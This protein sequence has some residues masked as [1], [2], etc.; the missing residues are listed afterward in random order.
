MSSYKIKIFYSVL[1]FSICHFLKKNKLEI[2]FYYFIKININ[3]VFK[4]LFF[5]TYTARD[6]KQKY[7]TFSLMTNIMVT[8]KKT[9]IKI[10]TYLLL[11]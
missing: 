10:K 9:K 1:T 3:F 2:L 6:Y 8:K 5:H 11:T 7:N 4:K